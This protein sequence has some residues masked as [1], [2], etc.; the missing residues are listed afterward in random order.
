MKGEA[1][2]QKQLEEVEKRT[3]AAIVEMHSAFY[4]DVLGA[5]LGITNSEALERYLQALLPITNHY[6]HSVTNRY[7]HRSIIAG[8]EQ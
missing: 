3:T 5:D 6:K 7:K 1:K 2:I 4:L 8:I